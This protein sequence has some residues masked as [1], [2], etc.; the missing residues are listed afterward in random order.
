MAKK[1]CCNC[2]GSGEVSILV[3]CPDCKSPD[4]ITLYDGAR[5]L[6]TAAKAMLVGK[7]PGRLPPEYSALISAIHK[8]EVG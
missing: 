6:L 7:I 3:P 5:E 2:D 8:C 1:Q 4:T